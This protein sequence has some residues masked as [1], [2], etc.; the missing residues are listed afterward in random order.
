MQLEIFSN[1]RL[2]QMLKGQKC[3]SDKTGLGFDKFVAYSS[4]IAS[5]SKAI[6]V[7][8]EVFEPH[9]ACLEKGKDVI[10]HENA[11]SE[12]DIPVKKHSESRIMPTCHRCGVI[13]HI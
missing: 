3:S 2:V 1:D 10:V 9:V 7:K 6:F 4:H 8:P 5:T 13:G 12:Y 11:K